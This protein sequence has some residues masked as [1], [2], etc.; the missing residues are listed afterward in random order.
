[1]LVWYCLVE[2]RLMFIVELLTA[3]A[4]TQV[5]CDIVVQT[6]RRYKSLTESIGVAR[7]WKAVDAVISR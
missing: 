3:Q 2:G 4:T 6:L 5:A 7:R 1:L